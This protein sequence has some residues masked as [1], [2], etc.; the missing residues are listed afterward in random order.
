[1]LVSALIDNL[2]LKSLNLS[3]NGITEVFFASFNAAMQEGRN[4]LR[5]INLSWNNL[6]PRALGFLT[7]ALE[8]LNVVEHLDLSMC[9][10]NSTH[11]EHFFTV[12][13]K[14]GKH[15]ECIVLYDNAITSKDVLP[16]MELLENNTVI[17]RILCKDCNGGISDHPILMR[18]K[19]PGPHL[20]SCC[21]PS[22]YRS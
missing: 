21:L 6:G 10:L 9:G 12:V 14:N 3:K 2:A 15:L 11:L 5:A 17:T 4:N 18:N 16:L 7:V 8:N 19:G 20:C 1:M 13:L 22:K